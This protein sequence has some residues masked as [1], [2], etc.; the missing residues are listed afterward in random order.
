V[1]LELLLAVSGRDAISGNYQDGFGAAGSFAMVGAPQFVARN[2]SRPRGYVLNLI[3]ELRKLDRS[4]HLH[5][6][7]APSGKERLGPL[8]DR[9]S[10]V[11]A[12]LFSLR[13]QIRVPRAAGPRK[14]LHCTHYNAP[15]LARGPLVVTIADVTPLLRPDYHASLLSRTIGARALGA[16]ARHADHIITV[17]EYSRSRIV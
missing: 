15:L 8:C 16:I 12:P 13:E 6:L 3:R 2:G 14:L 11:S 7:S 5:V 17:S 9:I 10:I 4:M 1:R